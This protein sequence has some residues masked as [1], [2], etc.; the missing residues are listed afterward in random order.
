MLLI[1]DIHLQQI[2]LMNTSNY[3]DIF[4]HEITYKK[5]KK[6]LSALNLPVRSFVL[7]TEI[8]M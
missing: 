1:F 8:W 4:L 7:V 3:L 5:K 6:K 2:I